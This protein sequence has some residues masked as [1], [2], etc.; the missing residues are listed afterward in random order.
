MKKHLVKFLKSLV[1]IIIGVS[2]VGTLLLVLLV[3][4]WE[5][6][7][8]NTL[9]FND[10]VFPV[11]NKKVKQGGL[12][13]YRSNYCKYINLPA[14]VSRS[15]VNHLIFS[16]PQM[17]TNRRTGCNVITVGVQIPPELPPG[18]YYLQNIYSYQVN[19][20]RVIT[21]EHNTESF[22]VIE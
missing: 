19:P 13:L 18:I 17:Y 11:I 20:L 10:P 7:P 15:F 22:E 3:V 16:S 21:L 5:D 4:V 1:R 2:M 12:L 6:W 14:K 9:K 8:Y